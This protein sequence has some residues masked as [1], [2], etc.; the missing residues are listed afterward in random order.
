MQV[1]LV[2]LITACLH[3]FYCFFHRW[4]FS[5]QRAATFIKL[6]LNFVLLNIMNVERQA[7]LLCSPTSMLGVL[8][9]SLC[10]VLLVLVS[11]LGRF[12]SIKSRLQRFVIIIHIK[13]QFADCLAWNECFICWCQKH[14][15]ASCCSVKELFHYYKRIRLGAT[16]FVSRRRVFFEQLHFAGKLT[17]FCNRWNYWFCKTKSSGKNFILVVD[18]CD[19]WASFADI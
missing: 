8:K 2:E 7:L 13:R 16:V 15:V 17:S 12:T 9:R 4:L 18:C 11:A 6:R 14:A 10:F 5:R 19:G 3:L 1:S